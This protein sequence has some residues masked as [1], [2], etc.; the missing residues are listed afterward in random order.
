MLQIKNITKT[1]DTGALQQKALNDVSLIF[2]I[3][4]LFQYGLSGSGKQHC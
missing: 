1:Y 2:E 4:S 3:M